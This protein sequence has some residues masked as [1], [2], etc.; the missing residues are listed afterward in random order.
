[1]HRALPILALEMSC[2]ARCTVQLVPIIQVH[3]RER[4][5]PATCNIKR[6]FSGCI[7]K[8]PIFAKYSQSVSIKSMEFL[9]RPGPEYGSLMVLF[10]ISPC[11]ASMVWYLSQVRS[12]SPSDFA[13]S[14]EIISR[15]WATDSPR[16]SLFMHSHTRTSEQNHIIFIHITHRSPYW[17]N[18]MIIMKQWIDSSTSMYIHC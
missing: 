15:S 9:L 17:R 6:Q 1:M 4:P 5:N 18:T 14:N 16:L 10:R 8:Y 7:T 11:H 13:G 12:P 2:F 3:H